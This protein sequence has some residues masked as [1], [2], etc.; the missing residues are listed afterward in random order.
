[1]A[2]VL[3][4]DDEVATPKLLSISFRKAGYDV[5]IANRGEEALALRRIESARRLQA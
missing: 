1:M 2:P 5:T 3:I 4:V